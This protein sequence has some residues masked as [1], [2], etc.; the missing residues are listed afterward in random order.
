V[1]VVRLAGC[2]NFVG[3]WHE[4]IFNAFVDLE[5][6]QRSEDEC[7]MRRFRILWTRLKGTRYR[8]HC[9]QRP[10]CYGHLGVGG[11]WAVPAAQSQ[12]HAV[13][14]RSLTSYRSPMKQQLSWQRIDCFVKFCFQYTALDI[15]CIIMQV[16]SYRDFTDY[17][18]L[19]VP[20]YRLNWTHVAFGRFLFSV[21]DYGTLCLDC[22]MTLWPQH[23][24]LWSFFNPSRLTG[25]GG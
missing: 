19:V 7:D 20:S 5:P 23:Y 4:F 25:G 22:C 10:L 9:R 12:M 18:Q 2:K 16:L 1:K 6:V 14:A 8:N 21:R 13:F 17:S 24:L 15:M 11:N 3:E